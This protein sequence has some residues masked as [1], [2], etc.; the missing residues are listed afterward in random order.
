MTSYNELLMRA[1]SALHARFDGQIDDKGYVSSI[2]K[3][4][5]PGVKLQ[6]FEDDLSEGDG[7][8]L[9][10]K[11]LAVHSSSALAV[12]TFA[13]FKD[14]PDDLLLLGR[15]GWQGL[16][17]ERKLPTGLGG[18]PPNL[19]VWAETHDEVLA[20]ESKFLEYLQLKQAK[21]S[22][23][24]TRENL[25]L[26]EDCW[27]NAKESAEEAGR[28]HLDAAQLVKHYF[29]IVNQA[30]QVPEKKATLCYLFWEPE[31][32]EDLAL[33]QRHRDE[34]A[35]FAEQVAPSRVEFKWMSYKDLWSEW[36]SC[37]ELA[38]HITN[39]RARYT[40]SI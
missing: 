14:Q 31:N 12:N 32:A 33:F 3:N 19:D 10:S 8:E 21:F 24:Y 25:P 6:Q 4:L 30:Q 1:K 35:T 22:P 23:K 13:L 16:Q 2:E 17:F 28:Q 9:E 26:V 15:R 18:T 29:G 20:I 27:W 7:N 40:V 38:E 37:P 5:L 39:L 34:T 36:S 11:F